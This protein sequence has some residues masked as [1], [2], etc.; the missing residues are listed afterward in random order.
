MSLLSGKTIRL[1]RLF[2]P[3]DGRAVCVAA[4]HGW[5]SDPTPNVMNLRKILEKVIMGKPDGILVSFGTAQR[6]TSLFTGKCSP[7]LIIRADWMNMPRLGGSNVSNILPVTNFK[8][9]ATSFARDALSMGA[10][11]ITIYYFIGYS[12]EFEALNI[13]QNAIFAQECRKIGLPIIIEPMAVGGPV[14][15]VNIAETLIASGRIAAELGADALKIPYTADVQT[16]RKLV[17]EAGVPVLVLGGAKSDNPRD[18]LELVEEAMQAGASGTV[19]GRNVTK[20][21][22]PAKMVADIY[23]LVH[24]NKSVDEILGI[25][26]YENVR[27]KAISDNCTGCE[28]CL[29]AC[30]S[31]H[32]GNFGES[33]ARLKIRYKIVNDEPRKSK[34]VICTLCGKC[35]EVC[36]T[37]ALRIN[38][39]G[40]LSLF[41]EL[42]TNCGECEKVCPFEVIW[43]DKDGL[44]VFCDLCQGNPE[45]VSACPSYAIEI[46]EKKRIG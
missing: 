44:P 11:A 3:H 7:A 35:V 41:P 34:P 46:I 33:S 6:M 31:S 30:Q 38:K 21:A 23:D 17:D 10:S 12:D 25:S 26:H 16:F 8:K 42:C 27:L 18:A 37:D 1:N 15:G 29:L 9:K 5:M 19:F 4:D 45:C 22:D 13:E 20:A 43:L 24:H 28:I 39:Q 36:P 40:Y 2:D 32:A 14:T